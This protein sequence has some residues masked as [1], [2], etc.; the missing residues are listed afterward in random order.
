MTKRLDAAESEARKVVDKWIAASSA[1][2]TYPG[3]SAVTM[4]DTDQKMMA[5]I[6]GAFE[7]ETPAIA[8]FWSVYGL[9]CARTS[10]DA[11]LGFSAWM[12]PWSSADLRTLMLERMMERFGDATITAFRARSTLS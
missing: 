8:T 10:L 3:A 9:A 4:F 7:V 11:T 1:C 6:A 12:M 5:R 2:A